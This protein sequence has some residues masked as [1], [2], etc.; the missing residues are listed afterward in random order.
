M[1]RNKIAGLV[2]A[3]LL[4]GLL[5]HA[6]AAAQDCHGTEVDSLRV[7]ISKERS[8]YRIGE[9]IRLEARVT[10][11]D[12]DQ[13]VEGVQV[14]VGLDARDV[15]LIGSTTTGS[16]GIGHLKIQ[17]KRYAPAVLVDLDAFARKDAVDVPCGASEIG[18][19]HKP[20]FLRIVGR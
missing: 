10:R 9:V 1:R 12:S 6:P 8:T 20:R 14:N 18:D 15:M 5:A 4:A 2:A 11:L 7:E 19:A 17:V 3:G 13:A 16:D